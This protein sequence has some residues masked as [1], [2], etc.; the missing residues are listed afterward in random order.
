MRISI[1]GMGYVGAVCA[2]CLANRGHSV[3]G[4][5]ISDIKVDLINAGKSPIVEP[6][7]D[8][9]LRKGVAAERIRATTNTAE[10][11]FDSDLSMICVGTP[12]LRNGDLDLRFVENVVREIGAVL[13]EKRDWHTIVVR[14]TVLPGTVNGFI[15]PLLEQSSGKRAGID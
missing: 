9:L 3:I 6:G 14:S 4:V 1:F 5:D 11:I 7:L 12:S 15:I 10:A 2:G 8:D 13:R